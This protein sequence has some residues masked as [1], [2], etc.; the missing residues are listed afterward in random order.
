M[1]ASSERSFS[2]G[3][4]GSIQHHSFSNFIFHRYLDISIPFPSNEVAG[5]TCATPEALVCWH[6]PK[7]PAK[8]GVKAPT[9]MAPWYSSAHAQYRLAAP[10]E[11]AG[12][13]S[14]PRAPVAGVH[15]D[16]PM[17]VWL[18]E[19]S[20]VFLEPQIK[21]G[22]TS[23]KGEP[24]LGDFVGHAHPV[25]QTCKSRFKS[26]QMGIVSSII[27]LATVHRSNSKTTSMAVAM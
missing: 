7:F 27:T 12:D 24:S 19:L 16:R 9:R 26:F 23:R 15:I 10:E 5:K 17:W 8:R 21:R 6:V 20:R 25:P 13:G 1:L 22:T 14:A 11:D 4:R 2:A 3:T 18:I